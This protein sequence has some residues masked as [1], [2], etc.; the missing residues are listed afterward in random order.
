[1]IS[2]WNIFEIMYPSLEKVKIVE[3]YETTNSVVVA[4]Q[5]KFCQHY[6]VR[7]SPLSMAIKSITVEFNTKGLVLNQQ[8]RASGRPKQYNTIENIETIRLSV[9]EAPNEKLSETCSALNMKATSVS[10][11]GNGFKIISV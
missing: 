4:T 11:T 6:N 2:N 1:M 9:T 3:F 8:K 5:R 7:R 10:N